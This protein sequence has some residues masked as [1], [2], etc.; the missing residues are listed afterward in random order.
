MSA[1]AY[2][3]SGAGYRLGRVCTAVAALLVL[4]V[5]AGLAFTGAAS[6]QPAPPPAP[7]APVP[8]PSPPPCQGP[9]CIPQ[10]VPVLPG[11][12]PPGNQ[13]NPNQAPAQESSCGI[14]DIPTCVSDAIES[15]FRDL[16]TPGLNSLLDLLA[17]S[18][19][20]TPPLDQL[21]VMGQIWGS[22]Q[23]IVI[24][25]YATLI[26]VAGI[27]VMAHETL[28]TRHSIKEIL[29]RVIVGFLASNLSL[30]FGGKVIEIGNA[31]SR[32][33]LGDGL[34]PETAGRAMR[35]TLMHDLDGGGLFVIFIALA[36]IVMLVAVLLTYIVR[37]TLTIILLAGAPILLMGHALPQTEGIAFWWWKA[38]AG[39]MAIQVGQSLALVAAL[40]LFFWPGGITLFN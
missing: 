17:K 15:F 11:N 20:V 12:Q 31:L 21:P 22:T 4:V 5:A 9:S 25:V 16:V 32:A 27:I 24:A 26:L 35:E 1:A 29:P 2:S 14:T 38:F 30:F 18:L 23:Q 33:I 19:L 10:P 37:I 3:T 34:S 13:S 7:S 8:A 6:A 39:V 40:K 36:L 28:Q